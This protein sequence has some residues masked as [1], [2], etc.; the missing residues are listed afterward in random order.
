MQFGV[1]KI[2]LHDLLSAIIEE[3]M[4]RSSWATAVCWLWEKNTEFPPFLLSWTFKSLLSPRSMRKCIGILLFLI[5]FLVCLIAC[6]KYALKVSLLVPNDPFLMEYFNHS[7]TLLNTLKGRTRNI[8]GYVLKTLSSKNPLQPTNKWAKHTAGKKSVLWL[9]GLHMLEIIIWIFC[10]CYEFY[11]QFYR[12][13][14]WMNSWCTLWKCN[15]C[16]GDE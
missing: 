9:C 4:Y 13:Y 16:M 10:F 2:L 8:S 6:F 7:Q 5:Y 12:K 3:L 11:N 15:G 1:N 14:W